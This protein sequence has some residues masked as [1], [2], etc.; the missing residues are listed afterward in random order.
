MSVS[1]IGAA[2]AASTAAVTGPSAPAQ[3]SAN[4]P[5][6]VAQQ[7]GSGALSQNE[8]SDSKCHHPAMSKPNMSTQDF[9]ALSNQSIEQDTN[10]ENLKKILELILAMKLMESM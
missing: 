10:M 5:E 1:G 4:A 2:G 7:E 8:N 3:V 6:S 9:I